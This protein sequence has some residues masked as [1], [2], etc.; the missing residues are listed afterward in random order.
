MRMC[1][2]PSMQVVIPSRALQAWPAPLPQ[3]SSD[4]IMMKTMSA[5]QSALIA[6]AA[7][8]EQSSGVS[9]LIQHGSGARSTH[10]RRC[11]G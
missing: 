1:A 2:T 10:R 9:Y 6:E 4:R 7:I 11:Q 3:A 5:A 8:P